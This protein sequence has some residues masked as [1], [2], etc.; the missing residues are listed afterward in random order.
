V[1]YLGLFAQ[2][3]A[4]AALMAAISSPHAPSGMPASSLKAQPQ[5]DC[6]TEGG[7]GPG[8][9]E[10]NQSSYATNPVGV[11]LLLLRAGLELKATQVWMALCLYQFKAYVHAFFWCV[12]QPSSVKQIPFQCA[13]LSC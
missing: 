2:V 6:R 7:L 12:L 8:F 9:N 13:C 3:D 5:R 1:W 11:A 4:C 10:A